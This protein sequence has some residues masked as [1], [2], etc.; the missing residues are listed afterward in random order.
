[1]K[2]QSKAMPISVALCCQKWVAMKATR[3]RSVSLTTDGNIRYFFNV[4]TKLLDMLLEIFC[5]SP[6]VIQ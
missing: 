3:L 6:L 4:Q 5:L 2:P 1:M